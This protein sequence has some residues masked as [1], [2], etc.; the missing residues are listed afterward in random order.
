MFILLSP[1]QRYE[2]REESP[3]FWGR[4]LRDILFRIFKM[5]LSNRILKINFQ[6]IKDRRGES[7]IQP[8]AIMRLES[9]L[10]LV[11]CRR[12]YSKLILYV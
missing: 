5:D 12:P 8:G 3:L 1:Y 4:N 9:G 7:Q 6:M 11:I 2:N 10:S